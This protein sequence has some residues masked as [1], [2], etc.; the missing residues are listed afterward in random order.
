[1]K[2]FIMSTI[3]ATLIIAFAGYM[4]KIPAPLVFVGISAPAL[5]L[6]VR[7]TLMRLTKNAKE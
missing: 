3:I 7:L 4:W 6:L 1:M 2:M 5:L